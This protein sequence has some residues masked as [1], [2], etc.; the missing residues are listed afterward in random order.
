M[1]E[2]AGFANTSASKATFGVDSKNRGCT[3]AHR[4]DITVVVVD[5]DWVRV[6]GDGGKHNYTNR[7]G[8]LV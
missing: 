3:T 1:F 5:G 8:W 6:V 7:L 2:L 4:R